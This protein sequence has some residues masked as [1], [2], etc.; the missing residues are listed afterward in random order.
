[1][2]GVRTCRPRMAIVLRWQPR[3]IPGQPPFILNLLTEIHAIVLQDAATR[4]TLIEGV[5]R[6]QTEE[7]LGLG[8][9]RGMQDPRRCSAARLRLIRRLARR[10]APIDD[11]D[12]AFAAIAPIPG[13]SHRLLP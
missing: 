11:Q 4:G 1:V 13:A 2:G 12:R 3:R 10:G 8:D 5:L 9:G 7:Y 6:D